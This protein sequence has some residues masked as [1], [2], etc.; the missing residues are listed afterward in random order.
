MM[1]PQPE[2]RKLHR[3]DTRTRRPP[4]GAARAAPLDAGRDPSSRQKKEEPSA[5]VTHERRWPPSPEP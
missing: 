2:M 1:I 3:F 5:W 4:S